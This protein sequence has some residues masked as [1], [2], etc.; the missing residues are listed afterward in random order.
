MH[1]CAALQGGGW[2]CVLG[3]D[4]RFRVGLIGGRRYI[5]MN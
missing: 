5:L 4:N 1:P 3:Q 2:S